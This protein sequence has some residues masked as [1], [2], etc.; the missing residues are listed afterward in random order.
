VIRFREGSPAI[1]LAMLFSLFGAQTKA[2]NQAAPLAVGETFTIDSKILGETRRINVYVPP[3][4]A[5]SKDVRLPVLYMPDGGMAEDFLHIAGL[6]Q[7][8]VGNRTMRSFLLVGIENTQP[9]TRRTKRSRP[10]SAGLRRSG[11]SFVMS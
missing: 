5:E 1:L 8:S 7:V 9:K 2:I 10:L 6:V 3:G 4:Y 11:S